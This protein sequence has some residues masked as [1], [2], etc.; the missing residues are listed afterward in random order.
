[1]VIIDRKMEKHESCVAHVVLLLSDSA[2]RRSQ[3]ASIGAPR[4]PPLLQRV[5][6]PL[7]L[8]VFSPNSFPDVFGLF[9]WLD[10]IRGCY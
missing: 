3:H 10:W 2:S 1:M 4:S 6:F 9:D 5:F 8:T 7:I